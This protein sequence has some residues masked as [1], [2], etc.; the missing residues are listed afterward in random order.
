MPGTQL[1]RQRVGRVI[2]EIEDLPHAQLDGPGRQILG[3]GIDRD[4]GTGELEELVRVASSM[5]AEPLGP[6]T[7]NST[8]NSVEPERAVTT[9]DT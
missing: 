5:A 8:P 1:S 7:P 2:Q 4:Q 3:G 9:E 6:A